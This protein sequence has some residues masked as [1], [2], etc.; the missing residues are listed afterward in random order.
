MLPPLFFLSSTF[1]FTIHNVLYHKFIVSANSLNTKIYYVIQGTVNNVSQPF[2]FF[3][4]YIVLFIFIFLTLVCIFWK[5]IHVFNQVLLKI[6]DE[7][8]YNRGSGEQTLSYITVV[9]KF[10]STLVFGPLSINRF[11]QIC[12]T[13]TALY[14]FFTIYP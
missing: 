2:S 1:K 6:K 3:P 12:Y 13:G 14:D 11:F 9:I 8:M 10:C 5:F 4:L 7:I